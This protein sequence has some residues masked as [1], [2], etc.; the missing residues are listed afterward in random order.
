M[1]LM[2]VTGSAAQMNGARMRSVKDGV[3]TTGQAERGYR[4]YRK[5]CLKCHHP[6]QF[7]GP[8][9]MD[10]WAG[11]RVHDYL[12]VIRRTMPTENPGSLK[13]EDYAAI[14]AFL[15]SINS[16]PA[17]ETEMSSDPDQLKLLKLE[18]PFKWSK[19]KKKSKA[20]DK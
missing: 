14:V 12:E 2:P 7:A 20:K 16:V 17:G 18:G 6:R 11:A 8:A 19:P 3:Y 4:T 5:A 1:T 9:Y 15:L 13:R 10:S